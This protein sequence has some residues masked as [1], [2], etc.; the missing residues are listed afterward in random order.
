MTS[1]ITRSRSFPASP[2]GAGDAPDSVDEIV[3]RV[4]SVIADLV[5]GY[6]ATRRAELDQITR[7]ISEENFGELQLLGHR[8]K[9]SGAGYG[10][11]TITVLGGALEEAAEEQDRLEV[12]RIAESLA[13]YLQ[14][15]RI[16]LP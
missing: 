15:V 12:V 5:P 3:V 4:D 9:G 11:Q 1:Q 14:A 13:D 2:S 6:L 8:L 10:F 16:E 7:W